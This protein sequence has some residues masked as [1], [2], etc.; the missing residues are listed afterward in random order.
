MTA[1]LLLTD[2]RLLNHGT[3]PAVRTVQKRQGWLPL[4]IGGCQS[5]MWRERQRAGFSDLLS[6]PGRSKNRYQFLLKRRLLQTLFRCGCLWVID[7][8]NGLGRALLQ[9]MANFGQTSKRTSDIFY[10]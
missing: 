10:F 6:T 3:H 4:W 5:V 2:A 7:G 1:A 8:N 9:F